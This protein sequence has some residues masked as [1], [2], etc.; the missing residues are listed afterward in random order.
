MTA[1]AEAVRLY[2]EGHPEESLTVLRSI[3]D[4]D[5]QFKPAQRLEAAIN[6]NA[7]V[8]LAQ[9][10]GEL[11]AASD[12][13]AAD[14]VEKAR[15]AFE[16][17][18][19][20]AAQSLAQG[21]LKDLPGHVE[22]RRLAL[23]AQARLRAT[24]EVESLLAR[25]RDAVESGQIPEAQGFLRLARNLDAGHPGL[26]ELE[27]RLPAPAVA[28]SESESEF[29]FE[30]FDHFGTQPEPAPPMEPASSPPAVSS[31]PTDFEAGF[32]E[33]PPAQFPS[34]GD[35]GFEK[36]AGAASFGSPASASPRP[37]TPA[38]PPTQSGFAAP[39]RAV[40]PP[41]AAV[42]PA[43]AEFHVAPVAPSSTPSTAAASPSPG[44]F[45]DSPMDEG[46]MA[47]GEVAMPSAAA[48]ADFS[49]AV[50]PDDR[51]GELLDQG[52]RAFDAGD[53]Q[54]AI[55]TW[56]RIYLVDAH[57]AEAEL[58]IEQAR[59]RREEIDRLA[60]HRFYEAR[61]AFDQGRL[62]DARA[63]CQ[64]VLDLQ[65][66][67]LEAHDLLQR[68]ETPSALPPPPTPSLA[69]EEDDLFKDDFVPATIASTSVG[70]S[71]PSSVPLVRERAGT[72]RSEEKPARRIAGLPLPVAAAVAGLLVVGLGAGLYFGGRMLLGGSDSSA[73]T[74]AM[75]D[76][77]AEQGQLADAIAVL[78]S[79]AGQVEGERAN[80]VNDKIQSLRRRM[81]ARATP[82]P[83]FDTA[84]IRAAASGGQRLKALRM[85]NEGLEKVPSEPE[86]L[87]IQGELTSF[88][89]LL[90][91]LSAAV[92]ESNWEAA[93]QLSTTIRQEHPEDAE[94]GQVWAVTTF[95]MAVTL[96]R[97]YQVAA[98]NSLLGEL[99]REGDDPQAT[100]LQQFARAYLSRPADPRYELFV[101]NTELRKVE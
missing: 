16:R 74:I 39:E 86:L 89:K 96:L 44:L 27:K 78:E 36:S 90:P 28:E 4:V 9:L 70:T 57:H 69:A 85:V 25:A 88:S 5:A 19:F 62:D 84:A 76:G 54:A 30:V 60:E 14:A 91:Q 7:P 93:R 80:Q 38:P 17:R 67:H 37:G 6:A 81:K 92:R 68:I 64:E 42:P 51:V 18:D 21:V 82:V 99:V 32:E 33:H 58:R 35:Q 49:V 52:Q 100:K 31:P 61:E 83:S 26:A 59:R 34:A 87:A 2:R 63:L 56:S 29:E 46:G 10:L 23:E 47:F 94:I 48:P 98:A 66:Q 65:P 3:T 1:F 53:F 72:F 75:A 50:G 71:S 95:N 24:S 77:L 15:Q 101:S 97:K 41:S 8:D 20:A 40:P 12:Q 13:D 11:S 45:F 43:A 73:N 79:L 55:E 22:A